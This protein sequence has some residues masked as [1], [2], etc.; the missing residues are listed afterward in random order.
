MVLYLYITAIRLQWDL[1]IIG[2]RPFT[3]DLYYSMPVRPDGMQQD[4]SYNDTHLTIFR[5]DFTDELALMHSG[6]TV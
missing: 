6:L 1:L 4:G 5:K 2:Q 3:Q